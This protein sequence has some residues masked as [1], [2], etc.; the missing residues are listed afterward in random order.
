V[1]K[2]RGNYL[3]HP[4][5]DGDQLALRKKLTYLLRSSYDLVRQDTIVFVCGGNEPD[6]ARRRFFSSS[7]TESKLA[8]FFAS[9]ESDFPLRR[10]PDCKH[11]LVEY[12]LF[13]PESAFKYRSHS[14]EGPFELTKFEELIAEISLVIVVFPESP[15]SF[16]ETRYFAAHQP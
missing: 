13:T 12:D 6:H 4:I 3:N 9:L 8:S 14:G 5:R 2:V 7:S 16:C 1:L 10:N 15:G 11:A